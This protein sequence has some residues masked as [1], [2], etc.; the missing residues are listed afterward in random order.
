MRT[1]TPSLEWIPRALARG[2][3]LLE[4]MVALSVMGMLLGFGVPAFSSISTNSKIAAES[5]N[6]VAALTL[7]RNEAMKRGMRVSVCATADAATCAGT[8]DWSKGWIVFQDDSGTAGTLDVSDVPLQNWGAP[9]NGVVVATA[10]T[11]VSFSRRARG[12]VAGQFMVAKKG[13][14]GNQRRQVDVTAAGRIGLIRQS[15]P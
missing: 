14:S 2:F 4:L 7:A 15:C 1:T 9:A 13:C 10:A 5:G 8:A 12:E 11:F 6:L 3:S